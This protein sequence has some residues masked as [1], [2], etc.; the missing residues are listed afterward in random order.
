VTRLAPTGVAIVAF[1]LASAPPASSAISVGRGIAGVRLGMR[2]A[3]V[4]AKLGAPL[5]VVVGKNEFGTYTELRYRGYVVDFQNGSTVTSIATTLARERTTGGIG[6]GSLWSQVLARVKHVRCEGGAALGDCHVG[7]FLPGR[8]VTDF[9][10]RRSRV[11]RVVVG[12]V[13]D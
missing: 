1:A 5:R 6:V 4:R 2:Q 11:V 9:V 10:V 12:Y 8:T 3:L 7:D 13:L